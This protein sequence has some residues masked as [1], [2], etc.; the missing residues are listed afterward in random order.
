MDKMD[1]WDEDSDLLYDLACES[2][3][4][5]D[6]R[7]AEFRSQQSRVAE[8][9]IEYQQRFAIWAAH[10][11]VFARPSQSLDKRLENYPDIVD[12]TAR[13]LDILRR[14]LTQRGN[15]EDGSDASEDRRTQDAALAALEATLSRL[16]RLGVTIR[17][18]SREKM[19][20]KTRKFASGL[21]L[22]GFTDAS[23]CVVHLLY[24]STHHSLSEYLAKTMTNR[25][26]TMLYLGHRGGKL[27]SRRYTKSPLMP[28]I[29]EAE[30]LTM[31]PSPL[32]QT[33]GA[34]IGNTNKQ[35]S[36]GDRKIPYAASQSDLSTINSKQLRLALRRS[37]YLSAPTER[38]KGTSSIQV[39]QGNYPPAPFH[40]DSN[41]AACE[42]CGRPMDKREITESEWRRHTDDDLK[43]Y[44]C[45]SEECPDG[46]PVYPSF[47]PW[48][49]HMESHSKRWHQRVY[50]IPGWVCPVCEDSHDV[51]RSPEALHL[52]LTETH[53]DMFDASRLQA[54]ARQSKIER[55]RAW[56]ECPLCCFTVEEVP[57][58]PDTGQKRQKKQLHQENDKRPKTTSKMRD[59]TPSREIEYHSDSSNDSIITEK[60]LTSD[61]TEMMARHIA[62]HLQTLMLLTIRLASLQNEEAG[63]SGQDANSDSVDLGDSI[64]G[65]K[66]G[67]PD[68]TSDISVPEDL[69][70]ADAD[71]GFDEAIIS[72]DHSTIPDAD[73]DF[74]E[75]GVRQQY[76]GFPAEEDGFLQQLI[77]S[78]AYQAHLDGSPGPND[79]I[80]NAVDPYIIT[81]SPDSSEAWKPDPEANPFSGPN[82]DL[83]IDNIIFPEDLYRFRPINA[84]FS[85]DFT[86][87]DPDCERERPMINIVLPTP[88]L[89]PNQQDVGIPPLLQLT[90]EAQG[91]A[92]DHS[93]PRHEVLDDV[94]LG[95]REVKEHSDYMERVSSS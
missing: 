53:H 59:S 87:R 64:D 68:E 63:D 92:Q 49:S 26:V 82:A 44:P 30:E 22:K 16:N 23:R 35:T 11:G 91:L 94:E 8:L 33:P 42:W 25:F 46:H 56:N 6:A 32:D 62:G 19:V 60:H 65:L 51:Y 55:P 83:R 38:R 84:H 93:S 71:Q 12:L 9:L 2:E 20:I 18:T 90:H 88:P 5:F 43:P 39:S 31:K 85:P 41:I 66:A 81:V 73:V 67:D 24:P 21:D 50:L 36:P 77:R 37:D 52:H 4:L 58:G 10:L 40:K 27:Q 78:G 17:Q 48:L 13:L 95:E 28:T 75:I 57:P 72:D 69:E 54:V 45:I 86:S 3:A 1:I 7:I 70:M 79:A 34:E 47:G 80:P 89:P 74:S 14:S 76:D 61:D 15:S 29:G